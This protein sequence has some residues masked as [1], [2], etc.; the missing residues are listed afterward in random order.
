MRSGHEQRRGDDNAYRGCVQRG[1][2]STAMALRLHE[3]G[4]EFS[5]LFTPTGNELPVVREHVS[6]IVRL[7]GAELIEPP[8]P[9]L[10][11]LITTLG[12]LP[13][14]R[15]RWCTRMIK[16][17]P[18]IAWLKSHPGCVLAVGLRADEPERE[19]M[20]G[21]WAT[22]RYPLREW[23]WTKP[24][25]VAYAKARGVAVPKRTDC[26][27]CYHQRIEEW[28]SLWRDH[29]DAWMQGERW[30]TETGH[31]FRS[32]GRDTW[33]VPLVALRAAFES[34]REPLSVVRARKRGLTMAE[35]DDNEETRCRVCAG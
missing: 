15:M 32:P 29:L 26:A 7:T 3:L 23:G 34:G 14:F 31:T 33:P 28:W 4:E 22:Y 16:I 24:D 6:N 21:E 9:S 1:G 18:C 12:G 8:G 19:G 5:L 20:Y 11:E 25:V 27:V 10:A 13:N 35:I 17:V 2:D 30:E